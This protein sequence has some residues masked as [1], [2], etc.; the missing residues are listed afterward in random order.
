M[1][2]DDNDSRENE[3]GEEGDGRRWRRR[4]EARPGEILEAAMDMF[5]ERGFAATRMEEIARRAGVTKGTVYLYFPSKEALFKAA[6][7][8]NILPILEERERL[9]AEW[10]G[11][12]ADL[13]AASIRRWWEVM[14]TTRLRCVPRLMAGEAANFPELA[15]FYMEHVVYRSRRIFESVLHRGIASGEFRPELD[16]PTAGRVLQGPLLYLAT[17]M[18][19]LQRFDAQPLDTEV[20]LEVTIDIFLRGIAANGDRDGSDAQG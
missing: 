5:V 13:L 18:Q 4:A 19:S 3:A 8:N 6:V 17:H 1:L 14:G 9:A 15:S 7:E 10:N 12:S 11:S 16:V 2:D 20:F